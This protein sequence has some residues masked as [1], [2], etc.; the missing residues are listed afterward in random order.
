M[1]SNEVIIEEP[2]IPIMEEEF[3]VPLVENEKAQE[4]SV[5]PPTDPINVFDPYQV[6][7]LGDIILIRYT[8]HKDDDDVSTEKKPT[9]LI[10]TV[11]YSSPSEI[12]IQ[13]FDAQNRIYTFE[14]EDNDDEIIYKPYHGVTEI[15]IL[16]KRRFPSF[17]EQ[18]NFFGDQRIDTITATGESGPSYIITEV[19]KEKDV[20]IVQENISNPDEEE[21]AP[22]EKKT[23]EFN[24]TGI[25]RNDADIDFVLIMNRIAPVN[26]E[27]E[28]AP[29]E[30]GPLSEEDREPIG[31]E[32]IIEEDEA[33]DVVMPVIYREAKV[34]EQ[35]IPND[36]QKMDAFADFIKGVPLA[37]QT[38]P[39]E[40]RKINILLETLFYLKESIISFE[41]SGAQK[42]LKPI[43]AKTIADL[44]ESSAIPLGRPVLT[45]DKKVYYY[46]NADEK[47]DVPKEPEPR[48]GIVYKNFE[49]EL[50]SMK[51]EFDPKKETDPKKPQ[52]KV[53]FSKLPLF[54]QKYLSPWTNPNQDLPEG[55]IKAPVW[56]A[57]SDTDIFR[58]YAPEI[59]NETHKFI[60]N[61][62]GLIKSGSGN[63]LIMDT[64]TFGVERALSTTYRKTMQTFKKNK[65]AQYDAMSEKEVFIPGDNASTMSYLLFPLDAAGYL[66]NI[67]SNHLAVDSGLSKR[68]YMLMKDLIMKYGTPVQIGSSDKITLLVPD[69]HKIGNI[70]VEDNIHNSTIIA[71]RLHDTFYSLVHYNLHSLELTVPL[72][73]TLVAK[74]NTYQ[75]LFINELNKLLTIVKESKTAPL[76]NY[77]IDE[78]SCLALLSSQPLLQD[79]ISAYEKYNPTLTASDVGIFSYLFKKYANYAQ[80]SIGKKSFFISTA[81]EAIIRMQYIEQ[82]RNKKLAAENTSIRH[83][84]NRCKHVGTLVTIRK[85]RDDTERFRALVAFLK[86]FQG[87]VEDNWIKCKDC[88]K[89]LLCIHERKQIHGFLF[90]Q[91]KTETDKQI[92]L[93]YSGGQFQ[94]RYICKHCGQMIRDYEFDNTIEY[95]EDGRPKSG[96]AVLRNEEAELD[97]DFE[98]LFATKDTIDTKKIR[99]ITDESRNYYTVIIRMISIMGIELSIAQINQIIQRT[100]AFMTSTIDSKEVYEAADNKEP[101]EQYRAL[102]VLLGTA[103]Y[104][105]IEIQCTIPAYNR[106]YIINNKVYDL[107]GYP[108]HPLSSEIDTITYIAI[109]LLDSFTSTYPWNMIPMYKKEN[110]TEIIDYFLI[111]MTGYMGLIVEDNDVAECLYKRRKYNTTSSKIIEEVPSSFLPEPIYAI[112]K[113]TLATEGMTI[114]TNKSYAARVQY[115]IKM[116][117]DMVQANVSKQQQMDKMIKGT[118]F[119]ESTCC[120]SDIANP[121]KKMVEDESYPIGMRT[122]KP[123]Q[124]PMLLA[125]FIPR[126]IATELINPDAELYYRLFLTYCAKGAHKGRVHE[127]TLTYKCMWCD[128]TFPENPGMMDLMAEDGKAG[129][130]IVFENGITATSEEFMQLLDIIHRNHNVLSYSMPTI[131]PLE[132]QLQELSVIPPI[133]PSIPDWKDIIDDIIANILPHIKEPGITNR[134]GPISEKSNVFRTTIHSFFHNT[135]GRTYKIAEPQEHTTTLEYIASLPWNAFCDVLQSYFVIPFQRVVSNFKQDR[136]A[137]PFELVNEFNIAGKLS[138]THGNDLDKILQQELKLHDTIVLEKIIGDRLRLA[139]SKKMNTPENVETMILTIKNIIRVFNANLSYIISCKNKIC[140]RE[141]KTDELLLQYI[142]EIILYGSLTLLC[143]MNKDDTIQYVFIQLLIEQLKKFT[144]EKLSFDA[145]EIASRI[146]ARNEKERSNIIKKFDKM[147]D[148][149]KKIELMKK[150]LGLGD[151]A[152]G[153][154]KLIYAYDKDYYD[155][156]REKRIE[157]GIVDFPGLEGKQDAPSNVFDILEM[158]AGEEEGYDP[159]ERNDEDE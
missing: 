132:A 29:E 101:Y 113:K 32:D 125:P 133:T 135:K 82:E 26:E 145:K 43:S 54:L 53:D 147:S 4:E 6:V 129:K 91:E 7:Q 142:K 55:D 63:E 92:I 49:Q 98:E 149:E 77:L 84:P 61:T 154:T 58:L 1:S 157:A 9:H 47:I 2:D 50:D 146:E 88:N 140:F 42:V 8:T 106:K 90:P 56:N 64:I 94:G 86:H 122:L 72:Y 155:L 66:G 20:I 96:N 134:F 87:S 104:V 24:F 28:E 17:V 105:L 38:D 121:Q 44:V 141:M 120:A 103:M 15:I 156:E 117:H 40:V 110:K 139:T 57:F 111:I 10:G 79:E 124:P 75:R 95:D 69:E 22:T 74:I 108:L 31:I 27:N 76:T 68:P 21:A 60:K 99:F 51:K 46:E 81:R 137:V 114:Q 33:I 152:V 37:K 65:K 70:P 138:D 73:N 144:E 130:A 131:T 159:A 71:L 116:A 13:P 85:Q 153:G 136:F 14:I 16:R 97:E 67:R 41:S 35:Y 62:P 36:L 128:F 83:V 100:N 89:D 78:V 119:T 48:K 52:P 59:N 80:V 93:A 107:E 19:N 5:L 102:Y 30:V 150:K 23:I 123:A 18:Q 127:L 118:V 34:F 109:V 115:W 126:T 11:Y 45:I 143:M 12:S 158:G 3:V 39:K 25:P 151:W 148:E 112:R